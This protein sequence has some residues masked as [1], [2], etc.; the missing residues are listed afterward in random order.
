MHTIENKKFQTPFLCTGAAIEAAKTLL[1][2]EGTF[3]Y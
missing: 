2:E 1:L 3:I